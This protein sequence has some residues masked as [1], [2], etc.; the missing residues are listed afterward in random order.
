MCVCVCV[1]CGIRK[2]VCVCLGGSKSLAP[3]CVSTLLALKMRDLFSYLAKASF[4]DILLE[5]SPRGRVDR[6][7]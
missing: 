1:L 6:G 2:C 7:D 4:R 3:L 5:G